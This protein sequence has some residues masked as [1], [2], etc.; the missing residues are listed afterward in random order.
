MKISVLLFLA[1]G[2]AAETSFAAAAP[3]Q[4]YRCTYKF[5]KEGK[6]AFEMSGSIIADEVESSPHGTTYLTLAPAESLEI[7]LEA[8]ILITRDGYNPMG[9]HKP[10]NSVVQVARSLLGAEG[11]SLEY[12]DLDGVKYEL[13]CVL[14]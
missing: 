2:F 10:G 5:Q 1:L 6:P 12:Q 7:A 13:T 14:K 11:G 3:S 8:R 9:L 4:V